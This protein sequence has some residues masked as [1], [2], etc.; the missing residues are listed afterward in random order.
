MIHTS[1]RNQAVAVAQETEANR[2]SVEDSAE[3]AKK[4]ADEANCVARLVLEE[5]QGRRAAEQE[6]AALKAA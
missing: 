4:A 6:A 5:T 1:Q 2:R 3:S